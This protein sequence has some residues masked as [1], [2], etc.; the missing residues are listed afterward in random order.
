[1]YDIFLRLLLAKDIKTIDV[2]KA[3]GIAPSTFSDWKSGRSTPKQDKLQKIADYFGVT[4]EYLMGIEKKEG[5]EEKPTHNLGELSDEEI[6]FLLLIRSLSPDEREALYT[7]MKGL[8][9]NQ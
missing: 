3:T 4:V 2:S 1:M 9:S 8:S 6:K 5:K 7:V